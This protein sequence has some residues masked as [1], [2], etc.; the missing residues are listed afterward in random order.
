MVSSKKKLIRRRVASYIGAG[1]IAKGGSGVPSFPMPA[2]VAS[3]VGFGDSITVGTAASDAAHRWLNI[4]AATLGGTLLNQGISGTVLQNSADSGGSARANN[5]RDRYV[6]ALLGANKQEM[7]IIAY[8]VNDG[9]YTGAPATLNVA[10]YKSD[11]REIVRGLLAAGYA[12]DRIVIVT[13]H[14]IT[15]YG[16]TQGSAGFTGQ[17]R[18]GYEAFVQA[19]R[20]LAI[21]LGVFFADSYGAMKSAGA[22]P[23]LNSE[24]SMDGIHPGDNFMAVIAAAVLAARRV[25]ATLPDYSPYFLVDTFTDDDLRDLNAHIGESGATWVAQTG[26]APTNFPRIFGAAVYGREAADIVAASGVP[27]TADYEIEANFRCD[28][29]VA[30]DNVGICARMS[31]SANTLIY[32]NYRQGTGWAISK[33]VAGVT[34]QLGTAVADPFTAGVTKNVKLQVQGTFIYLYVDGALMKSANDP[35]IAAAGRAGMRLPTSASTLA[36]IK[37]ADIRAKPI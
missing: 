32:A 31:T 21:E 16:F 11:Y 1:I 15:D 23:G 7:A 13:P 8:G 33:V 17:T 3:V 12:Q 14:Y 36:N 34:T 6:A 25:S 29:V 35:D 9:R 27:P 4:V 18:V 5:G 24:G 20:E 28:S 10:N 22:E 37:I 30:G 26:Y 19:A 2:S